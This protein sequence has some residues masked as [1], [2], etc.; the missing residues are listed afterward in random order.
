M[1]RHEKKKE[2]SSYRKRY[3]SQQSTTR[4]GD[5][6][7]ATGLFGSV[8]GDNSR[9]YINASADAVT[10]GTPDWSVAKLKRTVITHR[11]TSVIQWVSGISGLAA[12]IIGLVQ[13]LKPLVDLLVFKVPLSQLSPR[14][15]WAY[16]AVAGCVVMS[17][18]ILIAASTK[19]LKK[20]TFNL[21]NRPSNWASVGLKDEHGRTRRY[22][23][24]LRGEC[25]VASC[26]GSLMFYN[27]PTQTRP[28]YSTQG[29]YLKEVVTKR[30]PMMECD[31]FDEHEWPFDITDTG[32]LQLAIDSTV[33]V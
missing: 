25:G 10:A 8:V 2:E 27:K 3:T 29:E 16:V 13:T 28:V 12:T 6:A 4:L 26:R 14:T 15:D 18:G 11:M 31:A 30:R 33:H 20:M 19:Y 9:V 32:E 22:R 1:S 24:K 17:L 21:A 7:S 23:V 5:A